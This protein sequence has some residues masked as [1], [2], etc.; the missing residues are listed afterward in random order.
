[1]AHPKG[2]HGIAG[3]K[4]RDRSLIWRASLRKKLER[5]WKAFKQELKIPKVDDIRALKQRADWLERRIAHLQHGSHY[6]S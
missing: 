5:G 3:A 6:G 2:K 1:M 4:K